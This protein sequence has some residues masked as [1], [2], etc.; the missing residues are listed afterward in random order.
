[1]IDRPEILRRIDE[2]MRLPPKAVESAFLEENEELDGDGITIT[3]R[4]G[5]ILEARICL[6]KLME[7]R[8]CGMDI[9]RDCTASSARF[10]PIR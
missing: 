1:M 2:E 7:F 3:C 8:K 10:P 9:R 5:H 4:D 6:T